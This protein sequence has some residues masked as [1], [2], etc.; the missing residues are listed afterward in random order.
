M[1]KSHLV[2]AMCLVA[3]F[4]CISSSAATIRTVGPF[5][6]RFY[7]AGETAG[8]LT[9]QQNWTSEQ[10]DDVAAA[11]A[12]W[13]EV[14]GDVQGR[15]II[16]PLF[17]QDFTTTSGWVFTTLTSDSVKTRTR[18]EVVWRDGGTSASAEGYDLR[19]RMRI[20]PADTLGTFQWNFGE[21]MPAANEWD[22]RT[23]VLHELGH[24]LSFDGYVLQNDVLPRPPSTFDSLVVDQNGN[25]LQNGTSGTPGNFDQDGPNYWTGPN[26]N[27]AWG[28]PVP[29]NWKGA[30]VRLT[31]F[32]SIMSVPQDDGYSWN[33]RAIRQPTALDRALFKDLGWD[34]ELVPEPSSGL[35]VMM[36]TASLV[37][38]RR[39]RRVASC[40]PVG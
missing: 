35:I 19:L 28:S 33:G 31:I 38:V 4:Q 2:V 23:I 8:G 26:A 17:W 7:G 29:I 16:A 3:T 40:C 5:E 1:T 21:D 32:D 36:M 11:A 24:A 37:C 18:A 13:D 10:M 30:H 39:R 27:A 20:Q 15:Q 9:G 22:F 14:I 6:L 34:V 25:K 12:A